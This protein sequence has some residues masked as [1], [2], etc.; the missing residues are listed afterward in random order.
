MSKYISIGAASLAIGVSI[1]TLR[2]WE[3]EGRFS[4]SFRT[5]GGHRRYDLEIIKETFYSDFY[6]EEEKQRKALAYCRVSSSDQVEDL[7][8]QIEY[9]S[10]YCE[11]HFTDYEVLSDKG[12]GLNYKKPGLGKLIQHILQ[13]KISHIVL[14]HKDRLLRFG[15]E[16][17]FS[18]CRSFGIEVIILNEKE[19]LSFEEELSADVIELITV[20]SSKLFS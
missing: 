1:S 12:S 15:S 18:L 11:Q 9:L 5:C 4:P 3:T 10:E 8:R 17:I 20:F 14:T 2:R 19:N 16:I 6:K 13:Q 7:K